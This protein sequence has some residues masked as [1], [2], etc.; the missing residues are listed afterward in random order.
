MPETDLE[1]LIRL[2]SAGGVEFIIVGALRQAF[3]GPLC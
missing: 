1:A 2:L 3:M